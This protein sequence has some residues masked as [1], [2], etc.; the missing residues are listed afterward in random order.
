MKLARTDTNKLFTDFILLFYRVN[1][2][3]DI[4]MMYS[5]EK[6]VKPPCFKP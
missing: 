5:I 2:Y 1:L 4:K 6:N 3:I